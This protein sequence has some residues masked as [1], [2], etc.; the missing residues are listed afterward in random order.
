MQDWVK[1]L[2]YIIPP[3]HHP[4]SSIVVLTKSRAYA[5]KEAQENDLPCNAI[6]YQYECISRYSK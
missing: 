4:I 1:V 6:F 5:P 3:L 2:M